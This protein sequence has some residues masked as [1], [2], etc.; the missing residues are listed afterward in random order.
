MAIAG[1]LGALTGLYIAFY[2]GPKLQKKL[3][4]WEPFK[5]KNLNNS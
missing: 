4:E 1:G 2:L 5:K 3:R